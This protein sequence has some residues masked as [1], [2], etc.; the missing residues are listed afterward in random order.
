MHPGVASVADASATATSASAT[1]WCALATAARLFI[2]NAKLGIMRSWLGAIL[3]LP[4]L[5][6][7]AVIISLCVEAGCGISAGVRAAMIPVDLAL[8]PGETN[9]TDAFISINQ[10]SAFATILT[11]FRGALVDVHIAIFA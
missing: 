8:V 2:H 11:G 3:S 6:T 7:V 4:L 9:R 10:V 1:A 5:W